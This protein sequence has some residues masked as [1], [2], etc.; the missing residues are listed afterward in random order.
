MVVEASQVALNSK[1]EDLYG[2]YHEFAPDQRVL[3][4][5]SKDQ[6]VVPHTR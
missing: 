6:L 5:L 3:L 4:V 1:Q 2:T